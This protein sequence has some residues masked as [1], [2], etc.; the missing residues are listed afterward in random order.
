MIQHITSATGR[1]I[2]IVPDGVAVFTHCEIAAMRAQHITR[3]SAEYLAM[4]KSIMGTSAPLAFQLTDEE[5]RDA[6]A[7]F[8]FTTEDIDSSSGSYELLPPGRYTAQISNHDLKVSQKG[9]KYLALTLEI[10][11]PT[12][13]GRKLF[14][15]LNIINENETAQKIALSAFKAI[16]T[17]SGAPDFFDAVL[18]VEDEGELAELLTQLPMACYGKDLGVQVSIKK[19]DNG[20]ND[21]NEVKAYGPAQ[22]PARPNGNGAAKPAPKK[23]MIWGSK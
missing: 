9:G 12:H 20:Y 22:A 7:L 17:N 2:Y 15:N 8:N 16:C 4:V 11:G 13:E 18:A 19:G 23:P 5:R 14:D 6:M 3:E 21:K 10:T 1:D